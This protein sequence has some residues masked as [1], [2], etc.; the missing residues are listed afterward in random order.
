VKRMKTGKKEQKGHG[1]SE[2]TCRKKERTVPDRQQKTRAT[3][4]TPRE[5]GTV[6]YMKVEN[7]TDTPGTSKW[8]GGTLGKRKT[9]CSDL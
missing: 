5:L 9:V 2:Q 4:K 6:Y 7:A 1:G 3:E 8:I